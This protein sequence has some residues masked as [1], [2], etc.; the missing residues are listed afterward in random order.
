VLKELK[1]YNARSQPF[2]ELG[3]TDRVFEVFL[4]NIM[5]N[6][7]S[8]IVSNFNMNIMVRN[9]VSER[10]DGYLNLRGVLNSFKVSNIEEV[11]RLYARE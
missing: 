5:G 2:S 9:F 7:F 1:N 10:D 8:I 4:N 6:E 3:E 11:I